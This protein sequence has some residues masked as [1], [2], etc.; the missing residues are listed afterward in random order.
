[1]LE[2]TLS[3]DV[4]S[5]D[6]DDS[7][8]V[9]GLCKD[10]C[11]IKQM[12]TINYWSITYWSAQTVFCIFIRTC[13]SGRIFLRA[14]QQ[15]CMKQW[16]GAWRWWQLCLREWLWYLEYD[17]LV[18]SWLWNRHTQNLA[19]KSEKKTPPQY[20]QSRVKAAKTAI[21]R[22]FEML[23]VFFRADSPDSKEQ[24]V[25]VTASILWVC[26]NILKR[27]TW[28]REMWTHQVRVLLGG[29]GS[30]TVIWNLSGKKQNILIR[31][32]LNLVL[33]WNGI[34]KHIQALFIYIHTC[35]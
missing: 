11:L 15:K 12:Y 27:L 18:F 23:D 10:T 20:N 7:D 19:K 32:I 31:T 28:N 25:R 8:S 22:F 30:P 29:L 35:Y 6:S 17:G 21:I 34:F 3:S 33:C 26:V 13:L 16:E 24:A 14:L 2:P 9:S 1:M 5:T 4:D